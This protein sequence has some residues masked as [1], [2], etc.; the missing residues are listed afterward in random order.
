M[1]KSIINK[2]LEWLNL[3]FKIGFI[4]QRSFLHANVSI[5]ML[6]F[7]LP[8]FFIFH[9]SLNTHSLGKIILLF[10][11]ISLICINARQS[12][13][14]YSS[15]YFT[16]F[17]C[18]I[19]VQALSI[20]NAIDIN[21]FVIRYQNIIFAYIFFI[22]L[23]SSKISEN[24]I[25]KILIIG[26]ISNTIIQ[27]LLLVVP[28]IINFFSIF[29]GNGYIDLINMNLN[30][31]R[32]YLE[33]YDEILIPIFI[34]YIYSNRGGFLLRGSSFFG[35]IVITI[36]SY[37]S[38]FRTKILMVSFAF[39]SSIYIEIKKGLILIFI[40]ISILILGIFV[41]YND[42]STKDYNSNVIERL[43]ISD[44]AG[45]SGYSTGRIDRWM[46]AVRMG[47]SSIFGVGLGNYQF[48]IQNPKYNSHYSRGNK[49]ITFS[50]SDP[51]GVFFSIFGESGILA[52]ILYLSLIVKFLIS[53]FTN[54]E[55][56]SRIYIISFWIFFFYSLLNPSWTV[57]YL[58]LFWI[59]RYLIDRK[60]IER[61]ETR[62]ISY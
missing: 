23:Y 18:L 62:K 43:L 1:I 39:I 56:L 29:I 45:I 5:A 16:I 59:L 24:S 49:E 35:I 54:K 61:S 4:K 42:I 47:T 11:L 38:G 10:G 13:K 60:K 14:I 15:F 21:L 57:K 9:S 27:F 31:N 53:D 6:L 17:S 55:D 37:L 36:F 2:K 33:S 46:D 7:Q 20:F 50:A 41:V 26:F 52:L 58:V 22:L 12:S 8:P 44:S 40:L 19:F 48:Y 34:T 51:H 3:C 32:I 30:R 25:I 28:N